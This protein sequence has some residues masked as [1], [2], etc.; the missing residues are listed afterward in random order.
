VPPRYLVL[1][2]DLT[3][4]LECGALYSDRRISSAVTITDRFQNAQFAEAIVIDMEIRHAEPDRAASVAMNA[5]ADAR[6]WGISRIYLKVDSTLRGSIPSQIEGALAGWP[7]R[8]IV[9]AP[10]YPRMG[11]TVS[12]DLLHVNG[13]LLADTAFA[14][15]PLDPARTSSVSE[16]LFARALHVVHIRN[17]RALRDALESATPSVFVCDAETTEQMQ[18][19]AGVVI[20]AQWPCICAGSAG[21]LAE[22]I[23][24]ENRISSRSGLI[25][26]GSLNSASLK[27]CATASADAKVFTAAG[28]LDE[29]ALASDVSRTIQAEG[30][31]IVSTA[32]GE[33]DP[34][35]FLERLANITAA[36][37]R[38][39]QCECLVIFGGDSAASILSKL[40][41]QV[42]HPLGEV[43]PGIP[44]SRI[45]V[46]A[47]TL[48]LITKA[49]GFG[50]ADVVRE[51]RAALSAP[52]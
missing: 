8:S 31:A 19:L 29:Q 45:N 37:I 16:K 21:L 9:F 35:H 36:V 25:V 38:D 4:A 18:E 49:G 22:L 13:A 12:N 2:D 44:V 14:Q 33:G 52:E 32:A 1:A 11:R 3:G 26:N 23:A 20:D 28:D 46:D 27:Q 15:D 10:A 7:G 30:W 48:K 51:L 17:A 5:I 6:A 43:L 50:K 40:S 39:S 42:I 24:L 41:V 47:R 34:K